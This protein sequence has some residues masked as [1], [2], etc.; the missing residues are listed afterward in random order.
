M[1]T[2]KEIAEHLYLTTQHVSNLVSQGILPRGTSGKGSTSLDESRKAYIDFLRQRSRLH[3][4]DIPNDINEERLRLTKNQAD[5]KEI[6]VAILSGKLI[7]SDDVISTWQ[8]LIANCRSKLLNIP[9]KITHQVLGLKSYAEIEDL[10]MKEV[11]ESL[12]EIAKS[13]LPDNTRENLETIN[14]DL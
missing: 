8:D 6:E 4:K 1:A 7:H 13:G 11:H 10:I 5:Q 2:H 9:A 14:T 12:N 3:L